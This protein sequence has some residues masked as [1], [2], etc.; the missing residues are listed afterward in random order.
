MPTCV[1][2]LLGLLSGCGE[3]PPQV[4]RSATVPPLLL[5]RHPDK[6]ATLEL[7]QSSRPDGLPAP[8]A[9]DVL[10]PFKLVRTVD[11]VQT[12]QAPLPFR[13]RKL[14]YSHAPPG[15]VVTRA[16]KTLRFSNGPKGSKNADSWDFTQAALVLRRDAALGEPRDGGYTL[17]YPTA[18][19]RE[20]GL[21]L[22]TSGLAPREFALRSLHLAD[23]TRTGVLLP[24][25]AL[26]A[27]DVVIPT[28]GVLVFDAT[29][30]PPEVR[31]AAR[32]DG[33]TVV[34]ELDLA[35]TVTEVKRIQLRS[36]DLERVRVDLSAWAGQH[37]RLRLR[38]EPGDSAHLDYVFLAEPTLYTPVQDPRRLLLVFI[39]TLR[40]DH[41]GTYGYARDTTPRLDAWAQGAAVFDQARS[42]APWTLPSTRT[43]LSGMHPEG[44]RAGPPLQERLAA[45]GWAT[46]AFVGNVYL[47]ANFD[48]ADGWSRHYCVNWPP[49]ERV[50]DQVEDFLDRHPDRDAMALLHVMDM[51]LPYNEPRRYQGLWAGD[52]PD[53]FDAG[54]T[55]RSKILKV[56]KEEGQALEQ[57]LVDRYD[58]N[59]RYLDDQLAELFEDLGPDAP[60]V[61][62]ADHGE[63]FWDHGD[64]EHGH[65][66]YDELLRVPLIVRAPGV[67][68]G[69]VQAPV[70][71]LDVAPTVLDLVNTPAKDMAGRSLLPVARGDAKAAASLEAR[72]QPVGRPLYGLELWGVIQDGQKWTTR[73]GD[74][75]L[76]DLGADPGEQVDLA[77][78]T[79]TAPWRPRLG[80]GLGTWSG[81]VIRVLAGSASRSRQTP[82][83]IELRRSGG[84]D[85]AWLGVDPMSR[86]K[87]SATVTADGVAVFTFEPGARGAR[88]LYARAIGDVA[89]LDGLSLRVLDGG[90]G[91]VLGT[92]AWTGDTAPAVDGENHQLIKLTAA[93]RTLKTTYGIAPQPP[94]DGEALEAFSS[95]VEEALRQLGYVE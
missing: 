64:F 88:E 71:L 32:S 86:A 36:D 77:A 2:I 15:A 24:A 9:I 18:T 37:A 12:W 95:E 17:S 79:D 70:S 22:A 38:T 44:W 7:P 83:V 43:V 47:S 6:L 65:S 20:D 58:Q 45:A 50:I 67:P 78:K 5:A 59:L 11:G 27:W 62:F 21:N 90:S 75:H 39:D 1:A 16:D 10:G 34:V 40:P 55:T 28:A 8:D 23:S 56:H 33:A 19:A 76:Y 92:A 42:V 69:R 68:A 63:E 73:A 31:V 13:S 14:F 60:I 57:Y 41:M 91:K 85:V 61:V 94:A 66:L 30:L 46:G 87:A 48:M 80:E 72:P 89:D 51:H 4:A 52:P 49:A 26:G 84:F 81:P 25:P 35:G 29:L 74:E 53:G 54:S 82:V 3:P 93:N